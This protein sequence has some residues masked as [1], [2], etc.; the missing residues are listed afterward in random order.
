M[1]T[2][3]SIKAMK[4]Y[5]VLVILGVQGS[6]KGTQGDLLV[7]KHGFVAFSAGQL[8]RDE[9]ASGSELGKEIDVI[10][11]EKG[12]LVPAEMIRKLIL[13]ALEKA[14]EDKS[15]IIDGY[16]R[17]LEQLEDFDKIIKESGM[18]NYK[19]LDIAITDDVAIERLTSR[20]VLD[21]DGN[22]V[23]RAD[24][25][26]EKIKTRL[27]WSHEETGPVMDEFDTRGK[28]VRINGEQSIEEVYKEVIEKLAL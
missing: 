3:H 16:P 12:E 17:S 28:L 7:E 6:G 10:I 1:I 20:V 26:I 27:K 13:Q 18:D 4:K 14:P 5:D 11:N 23:K 21:E 25:D 22:E 15:I 8:L 9:V 19:V 2:N 24:D